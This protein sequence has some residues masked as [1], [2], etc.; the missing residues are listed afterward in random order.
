MARWVSQVLLVVAVGW[1]L[2]ASAQDGTLTPQ[3]MSRQEWS[4]DKAGEVRDPARDV[5]DQSAPI[6]EPNPFEDRAAEKRV[7]VP[8]PTPPPGA[9]RS[10]PADVLALDTNMPARINEVLTCRLKIA[11]DRRVKLEQVAAGTVLLR[12]TVEPGGGVTNAETVARKKTDPEVL[13]CIRR[14]MEE[15]VFIRGPGGAPMKIEQTV[16]FD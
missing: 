10:V 15:W 4:L 16:K 1:P 8:A 12:W 11:T 5:D 9:A 2:T 7:A 13:S 6:S 14:Q 3:Q